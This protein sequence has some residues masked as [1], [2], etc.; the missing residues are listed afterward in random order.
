MKIIPDVIA[1]TPPLT[2]RPSCNAR[3]AARMMTEAKLSAIL[4]VDGDGRLVGIATE[5]DFTRSFVVKGTDM[6][7]TVIGDIMTVRAETLRADDPP[8]AA[9]QLMELRSVR[10]L[11]VID[12][13]GRPL[14]IVTILNLYSTVMQANNDLM[15]KTQSYL[16]GDR[17]NYSD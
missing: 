6:D 17:H 2:V 13:D 1:A 15:A 4:I 12:N 10:H 8:R 7:S 16:F 11:P 5:R 9:L 3:E 14:A